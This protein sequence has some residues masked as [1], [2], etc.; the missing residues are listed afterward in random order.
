M[1][2]HC[3]SLGVESVEVSSQR[4]PHMAVY[5][6]MKDFHKKFPLS[7]IRT[8]TDFLHQV[9]WASLTSSPFSNFSEWRA[10]RCAGWTSTWRQDIRSCDAS[11]S[12]SG[13]Y[14]QPPD[15]AF[16][17][18]QIAAGGFPVHPDR[19]GI[20]NKNIQIQMATI[21]RNLLSKRT[22]IAPDQA[23]STVCQPE[24][25]KWLSTPK[26]GRGLQGGGSFRNA[27]MFFQIAT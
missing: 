8:R 22:P 11:R 25:L 12:M 26:D 9:K 18:K 17:Q 3:S 7:S 21:R 4:V 6:D 19:C 13:C 5:K 10:F 23:W 24:R 20:T 15:A 1:V 27:A 14:S 16:V 2:S